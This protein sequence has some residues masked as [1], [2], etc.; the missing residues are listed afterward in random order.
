MFLAQANKQENHFFKYVIGFIIVIAAMFLGY[1]PF[2]MAIAIKSMTT[3]KPA[4]VTEVEMMRYLDLNLGLFLL[5][6]SFAVALLALFLVVK[7]IHKQHFKEIIT[8]RPKIDWNRFFFAFLIWFVFSAGTIVLMYFIEPENYVLQFRL[9][10]FLLLAAI[11]I[12]MI[13]VQTSLEELLFRGYLMQGFGLLARNRWVPL[14]ITSVGFGVLHLANPEVDKMGY[15]IAFY[16]IGTGLFLGIVTLMDEGTE[17]PLGFHAANNVTA[18]LLIT[19]DWS[20][21]QTHSIFKDISEPSAGWD[22][23]IPLFVIYPLLLLIFGRKYKWHSW[24]EKLTG[25]IKPITIPDT[26]QS[27]T[28]YEQS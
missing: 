1:L 22:I 25:K 14:V 2:G 19:S 11:A 12:V 27:Y 6:L 4:P 18:A 3:G 26:N 20:A 23:F 17:L 9:Q 13:P 5:L 7:G 16:Y 15:I 28:G 10:P 24:K 8:S 21:F